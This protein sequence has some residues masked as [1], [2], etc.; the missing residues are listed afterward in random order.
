M[1]TRRHVLLSG[2]HLCV[3]DLA[4]VSLLH[5]DQALD[6]ML[7]SHLT[8]LRHKGSQQGRGG[9]VSSEKRKKNLNYPSRFSGSGLTGMGTCQKA[10]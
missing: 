2:V 8:S 6:T 3:F 5:L 9:E 10:S 1:S 4:I 7:C